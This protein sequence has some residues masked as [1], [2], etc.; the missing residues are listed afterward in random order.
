MKKK[1]IVLILTALLFAA[2]AA[3]QKPAGGDSAKMT[4]TLTTQYWTGWSEEQPEATVQ[5]FE[6]VAEGTVI[7][8]GGSFYGIV[9]V[10]EVTADGIRLSLHDSCFVEPNDGGGI[11]LTAPSVESLTIQLGEEKELVSKSL[12]GGVYLWIAL[13]RGPAPTPAPT[14][15]WEA[16]TPAPTPEREAEDEPLPYASATFA[17]KNEAEARMMRLYDENRALLMAVAEDLKASAH[18]EIENGVVY[19]IRENGFADMTRPY[20]SMTDAIR[21]FLALPDSGDYTLSW[22]KESVFLIELR[23]TNDSGYYSTQLVYAEDGQK[24]VKMMSEKGGS[25]LE[26]L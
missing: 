19:S 26:P 6:N 7:Y 9:E 16:K 15:S 22:I 24:I 18:G 5:S 1:W 10:A 3:A 21:A 11:N 2:C 13:T 20:A 17:N 8:D 12:D 25:T 4:L 14:P 23:W